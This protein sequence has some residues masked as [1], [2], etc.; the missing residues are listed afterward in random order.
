MSALSFDTS[1]HARGPQVTS[2]TART[3]PSE[4]RHRRT[5]RCAIS[6]FDAAPSSPA[7][8]EPTRADQALPRHGHRPASVPRA[9]S[10]C[11]PVPL[12]LAPESAQA[13]RAAERW[14]GRW[15]RS[16]PCQAIVVPSECGSNR[17]QPTKHPARQPAA[18]GP[19][20]TR[21]RAGAAPATRLQQS[22]NIESKARAYSRAKI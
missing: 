15:C 22:R 8:G 11:P 2:R 19:A 14:S 7:A 10:P 13:V 5:R 4:G 6:G 21:P 18:T 1:Y 16:P 12:E 17:R 20:R 9:G 3:A